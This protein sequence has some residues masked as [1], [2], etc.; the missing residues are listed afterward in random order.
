MATPALVWLW[1]SH[2]GL[3]MVSIHTCSPMTWGL[4][5]YSSSHLECSPVSTSTRPPCVIILLAPVP[6][7]SALG[8][9]CHLP[10]CQGPRLSPLC[11]QSSVSIPVL[12]GTSHN[13]TAFALS[14]PSHICDVFEGRGLQLS[15]TLPVC[16]MSP[17]PYKITSILP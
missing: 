16:N 11:A 1:S 15:L 9:L 5:M 4:C 3:L 8:N 12:R 7:S 13:I 10:P 14:P 6:A 17:L 2:T